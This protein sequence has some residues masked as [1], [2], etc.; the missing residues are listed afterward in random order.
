MGVSGSPLPTMIAV[1]QDHSLNSVPLQ[2]LKSVLSP[3]PIPVVYCICSF[4]RWR[5]SNVESP[6]SALRFSQFC[7][8]ERVPGL[9]LCG[10]PPDCA[11]PKLYG[12]D[13]VFCVAADA[14]WPPRAESSSMDFE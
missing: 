9:E 2:P 3:I 13:G 10:A 7:A 4:N 1:S 14:P 6:R 12:L 11:G 5:W 8:I